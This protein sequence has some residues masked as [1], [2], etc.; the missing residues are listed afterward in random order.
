M[1]TGLLRLSDLIV[2]LE[3]VQRRWS[4]WIVFYAVFFVNFAL[5]AWLLT[6]LHRHSVRKALPW[7]VSY[8]AWELLSIVVGL[9][10]AFISGRWYVTAYWWMEGVRVTLIVGAVR[11]SFVRTFVGFSSLRWF[12]WVVR[13]VIVT[14]LAYSTW[15]AVYA[16]PI[17]SNHLVSFILAGEFTFRWGIVGI[18][19]LSLVL[20]WLLE[21]PRDTREAV[22]IGGCAIASTAFLVNVVSRSFFGQKYT[23]FTQYV[24]DIGYFL[25]ATIWIRY[26][27]YPERY[28]GFKELG[29]TPEEMALELRR[30]RETAEKILGKTK[31]QEPSQ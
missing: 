16:P 28:F 24:P 7:F 31:G 14:V 25:A 3:L 5:D 21:L 11:E 22:V 9:V 1:A 26:M 27:R 4:L 30:Y 10:A 12:P 6:L 17:Q 8:I 2:A 13:G 20:E 19:L 18:G 29:I 23:W 15:K